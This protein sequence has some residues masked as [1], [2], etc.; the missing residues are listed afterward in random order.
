MLRKEIKFIETC[1]FFLFLFF[2]LADFIDDIVHNSNLYV[3]QEGKDT[4][5]ETG[6]E[7]FF[8]LVIGFLVQVE[9]EIALF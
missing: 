8:F 3:L 7:D 2:F 5:A 6:Q 1:L 4:L 9:T